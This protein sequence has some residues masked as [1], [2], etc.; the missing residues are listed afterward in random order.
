M[1]GTCS[2]GVVVATAQVR[3]RERGGHGGGHGRR[4]APSE[5]GGG[6][7]LEG[8]RWRLR[9]GRDERGSDR[10]RGREGEGRGCRRLGLGERTEDGGGWVVGDPEIET[11]WRLCRERG[12]VDRGRG[13]DRGS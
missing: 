1:G 11:E 13:V 3:G 7:D 10:G 5:G 12:R 4:G 8:R 9:S 6:R 2:E